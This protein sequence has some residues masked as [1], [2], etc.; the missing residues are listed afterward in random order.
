MG[1]LSKTP[2]DSNQKIMGSFRFGIALL[3]LT[4]VVTTKDVFRYVDEETGQSHYMTGT[5]AA[6]LREVGPSLIPMALSNWPTKPMK[7][8]SNLRPNISLFLLKTLMKLLR[9]RVHSI[10][11]PMN[12]KPKLRP[13]SYPRLHTS[14][15]LMKLLKQKK[16]FIVLLKNTKPRLRLLKLRLLLMPDAKGA[17]MMFFVMKMKPLDN[18]IT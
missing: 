6:L 9:L 15:T 16:Y 5:L 13:D 2:G 1:S 11:F 8:G 7:L 17:Q 12:T 10:L 18:L 14:L 4:S 3:V